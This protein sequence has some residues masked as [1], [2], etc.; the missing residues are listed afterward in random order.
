MLT[1][2]CETA[3]VPAVQTGKGTSHDYQLC[4][5]LAVKA[6]LKKLVK[7]PFFTLKY[8]LKEDLY[9]EFRIELLQTAQIKSISQLGC[10]P[11]LR[12]LVFTQKLFSSQLKKKG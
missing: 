6:S 10:R 12:N 9:K 2:S 11:T 3:L 8:V 1:A 7:Y 4:A 5:L